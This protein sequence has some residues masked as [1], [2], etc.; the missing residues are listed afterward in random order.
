MASDSCT[1]V[2]NTTKPVG[3]FKAKKKKFGEKKL[4]KKQR[5]SLAK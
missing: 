3:H 4:S 1:G 5:K 2:G